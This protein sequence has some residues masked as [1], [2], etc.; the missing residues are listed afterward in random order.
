MDAYTIANVLRGLGADKVRVTRS[1]KVAC[2]CLLA[3]W[4]HRYGRDSTPSMVVYVE[5]DRVEGPTYGCMSCHDSGSL[6]DLLLFMRTRGRHDVVPW[7]QVLE[8]E[9]SS[10]SVPKSEK[11]KR[12][13]AE[14]SVF[15]RSVPVRE[16]EAVVRRTF[17]DGRP[18]YDY[19]ALAQA[20]EIEPIEESVYL[21]YAGSVPRYALERGLVIDTCK[22]FE[23]G[24]DKEMK[25][26]LFPI[27]DR[28]GRLVAISGRLYATECVGCG[29]VWERRCRRCGELQ[30]HHER[31]GDDELTDLL[32]A[33]GESWEPQRA[34]CIV[35][36][37]PE[38]PKYLHNRG[39]KRNLVLY[40][41]HMKDRA[42]DGR[43]YVVEGHL[44]MI[45]MWQA[46]YRP[47]V[48]MLGSHPGAPQIEKLIKYWQKVIVIGDGNQAGRD[49]AKRVKRMIA[50]RIPVSII[51]LD[52]R[53]DPGNMT[54]EELREKV[55]PPPV[56]LAA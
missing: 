52:D 55:G 6:I 17:E 34:E 3:P 36:S 37:T 18:F 49:M 4:T 50:D 14:V 30:R 12:K 26:L 53:R 32:C 28:K 41:E 46:G 8:G 42:K 15:G 9:R 20:E 48:A 35:C 31:V 54:P 39:F 23:L 2:C 43:V 45:R 56:L 13:V 11:L 33:D 44:D 38:P 29:G 10:E 16:T 51:D 47:V 22:A 40:G 19:K 7:L 1:G 27:R 24:N 5:G 25:R 21:P